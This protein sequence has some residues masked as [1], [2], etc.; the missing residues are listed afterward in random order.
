VDVPRAVKF[1]TEVLGG[2]ALLEVPAIG[3]YIFKL[4][5]GEALLGLHQHPGPLPAPDPAG[6]WFWLEVE[7][8]GPGPA[9]GC[10]IEP[11]W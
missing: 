2:V 3:F 10:R 5:E 1:Y 9:A 8:L 7:D 11:G 4:P 6:T